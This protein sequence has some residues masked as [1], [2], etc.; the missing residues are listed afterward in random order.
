MS[1]TTTPQNDGTDLSSVF[2]DEISRDILGFWFGDSGLH[3]TMD[4]VMRWFRT[5]EEFDEQCR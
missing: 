3:P 5:D 4:Q 1:T 2:T